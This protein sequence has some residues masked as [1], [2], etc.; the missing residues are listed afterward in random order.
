M[1]RNNLGL[2]TKEYTYN[3]HAV[4]YDSTEF[5]GENTGFFQKYNL[6]DE[7][8]GETKQD[9][10]NKRASEA[11]G[12][13]TTKRR[14]DAQFIGLLTKPHTYNPHAVVYESKDFIGD[15]EPMMLGYRADDE[16]R[17][18]FIYKGTSKS[19]GKRYFLIPFIDGSN[20]KLISRGLDIS[21][22]KRD[23]YSN[24]QNRGIMGVLTRES[25]ITGYNN[26]DFYGQETIMLPKGSVGKSKNGGGSFIS[27][28]LEMIFGK[29]K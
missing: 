5:I 13:P 27:R 14:R 22:V 20:N 16:A 11:F 1:A 6:D 9:I 23:I 21:G 18:A 7:F 4:V 26:V 2:L 24:A 25:H 8:L 10:L 12:V 28:L 17:I 29:P 15:L 3:P 19:D